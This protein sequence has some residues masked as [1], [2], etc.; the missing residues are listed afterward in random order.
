[1]F[2]W[3]GVAIALAGAQNHAQLA[4]VRVVLGW[5]EAGFSPGVIFF[6]SACKS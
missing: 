4:G 5:A 3:G 6:L 2:V 1:M